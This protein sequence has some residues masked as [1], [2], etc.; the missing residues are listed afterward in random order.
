MP[1]NAALIEAVTCYY[2]KKEEPYEISN[3]DTYLDPLF[4]KGWTVIGVYASVLPGT[5]VWQ[6]PDCTAK[7]RRA[8]TD[9]GMYADFGT[10]FPD[11]VWPGCIL[12]GIP[13]N[14]LAQYL[15]RTRKA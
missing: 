1:G 10:R 3:C 2:C 8:S 7:A 9:A 13:G 4:H 11:K 5:N 12:E 6:C 15:N 14:K